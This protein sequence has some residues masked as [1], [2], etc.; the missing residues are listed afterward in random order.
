[1]DRDLMGRLSGR[2][3][4]ASSCTIFSRDLLMEKKGACSTEGRKDEEKK[5]RINYR[6]R[7]VF[8][9]SQE[10]TDR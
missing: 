6:Y 1:M 7:R 3:S 9:V 10:S 8:V 5:A 2:L 4:R